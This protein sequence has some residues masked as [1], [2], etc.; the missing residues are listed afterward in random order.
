M[1][2]IKPRFQKRETY[3]THLQYHRFSQVTR[4][5]ETLTHSPASTH[6]FPIQFVCSFQRDLLK[7]EI[8][9][10]PHAQNPLLLIFHLTTGDR[11]SG[12]DPSPP[13]RLHLIPSLLTFS[14]SVLFSSDTPSPSRFSNCVLSGRIYLQ[15]FM[16]VVYSHYLGLLRLASPILPSKDSS[17]NH[18]DL[19]SNHHL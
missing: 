18:V 6:S 10:P 9:G 15:L 13:L 14:H 11:V 12:S 19:H 4:F 3:H 17:L 2:A 7:P 1:E 16:R 8:R 5:L